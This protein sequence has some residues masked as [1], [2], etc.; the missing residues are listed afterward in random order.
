MLSA[1]WKVE[2]HIGTSWGGLVFTKKGDD[3]TGLDL[4]LDTGI[5]ISSTW[6]FLHAT[7]ISIGMLEYLV[8]LNVAIM[9]TKNQRT[10][11]EYVHLKCV[12]VLKRVK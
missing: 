4:K 5:T 3:V 11:N 1:A 2:S 8:H 10:R 12:T 6:I 7:G 9:I